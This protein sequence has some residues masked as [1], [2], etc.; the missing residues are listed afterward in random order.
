M[1]PIILS[2]FFYLAYCPCSCEKCYVHAIRHTRRLKIQVTN[3]MYVLGEDNAC[4]LDDD[5][6]CKLEVTMLASW[7]MKML[8]R[9]LWNRLDDDN[10]CKFP[11]NGVAVVAD[12]NRS[13]ISLFY[14]LQ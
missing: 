14:L 2:V 10:A 8:A 7:M 3:G 1:G 4:K 9:L 13:I 5:N 11:G 12:G 6:A